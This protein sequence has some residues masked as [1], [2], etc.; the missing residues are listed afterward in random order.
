MPETNEKRQ[1]IKLLLFVVSLRNACPLLLSW[2]PLW[3]SLCFHLVLMVYLYCKIVLLKLIALERQ[4]L[5]IFDNLENKRILM[6]VIISACKLLIAFDEQL[7]SPRFLGWWRHSYVPGT[8]D[9]TDTII[10][11]EVWFVDLWRVKLR[12]N[13]Y[14]ECTSKPAH[15]TNHSSLFQFNKEQFVIISPLSENTKI[16][17]HLFFISTCHEFFTWK[18]FVV[19]LWLK[20]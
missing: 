4:W 3:Y 2:I 14:P 20:T 15:Q 10:S 19:S 12:A 16:T 6:S 9:V 8:R 7:D 18:H 13:S 17:I 11:D 5:Y 1:Y